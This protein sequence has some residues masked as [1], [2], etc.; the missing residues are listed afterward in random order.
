MKADVSIIDFCINPT[1]VAAAANS[2]SAVR[3]VEDEIVSASR[4][5]KQATYCFRRFIAIAHPLL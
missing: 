1:A 5:A 2:A 3:E 4:D